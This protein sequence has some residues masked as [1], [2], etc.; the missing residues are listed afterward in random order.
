[1]G[2][3]L[4]GVDPEAYPMAALNGPMTNGMGMGEFSLGGCRD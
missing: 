2:W 1:M 3:N 4:Y